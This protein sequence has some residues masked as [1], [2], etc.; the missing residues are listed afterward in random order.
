MDI[1]PVYDSDAAMWFAGTLTTTP[2]LTPSQRGDY[3][4]WPSPDGSTK[5]GHAQD[6]ITNRKAVEAC[7]KLL[8]L[9]VVEL[10][11]LAPWYWES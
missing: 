1:E 9:P 11:K 6:Y 5:Y 3:F 4:A 10:R 8:A 2:T 7:E